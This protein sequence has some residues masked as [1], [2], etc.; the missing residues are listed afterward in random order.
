MAENYLALK[1]VGSVTGFHKKTAYI[2][3]YVSGIIY[4]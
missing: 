1:K 4:N 2:L 3:L